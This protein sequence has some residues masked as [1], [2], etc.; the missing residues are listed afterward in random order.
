MESPLGRATGHWGHE[1]THNPS[2]RGTD[3]ARTNAL[4]ASWEG[5]GRFMESPHDFDV[6][7]WD[8]EHCTA[9]ART[10]MSA[11]TWLPALRFIE[12]GNRSTRQIIW[13]N[14]S[15]CSTGFAS[16]VSLNEI[17]RVTAARRPLFSVLHENNTAYLPA[18][19]IAG[20]CRRFCPAGE[21]R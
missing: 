17:L 18:W 6:V 13:T 3:K 12:S 10:A 1:P 4:L 5:S 16:A 19:H 11:R 2:R 9:G 15:A 7:L 21:E 20:R 14:S 8:H